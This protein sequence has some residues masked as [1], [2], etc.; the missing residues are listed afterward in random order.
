MSRARGFML[1]EVIVA[2]ALLALA[3]TFL[4]GA[5][6]SASRQVRTADSAGRATL[7]A[8]SL[9][10]QVGVGQALQP[11]SS[12]GSLDGGR[13]RWTLDVTPFVDPARRRSQVIEVGA[14]RLL[15]LRLRMQ[16]GD[17]ADQ[18]LQWQTLRLVPP[19]TVATAEVMP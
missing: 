7:H 15:Q 19:D 11:G 2:F 5:L 17:R 13:Y 10:A 16:W 9:L 6:S 4:L 12:Q 18:R 1:I 8:Q 14:P 3:L